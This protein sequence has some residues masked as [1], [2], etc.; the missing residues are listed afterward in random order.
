MSSCEAVL[1]AIEALVVGCQ[2]QGTALPLNGVV[3]DFLAACF[4]RYIAVHVLQGPG[5]ICRFR[6]LFR[7]SFKTYLE[8]PYPE[9][10]SAWLLNTG[11]EFKNSGLQDSRICGL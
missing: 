2:R 1:F 4:V 9:I 3:G 10:I 6:R 11:F 8:N 7:I 5:G